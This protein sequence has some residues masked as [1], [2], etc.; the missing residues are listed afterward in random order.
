MWVR[1]R[2]QHHICSGIQV[3][4]LLPEIDDYADQPALIVNT[5]VKRNGSAFI[6]MES[7]NFLS[8]I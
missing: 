8:S 5:L 2:E 6:L 4:L 1:L 3:T 7:C